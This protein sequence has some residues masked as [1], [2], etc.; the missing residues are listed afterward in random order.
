MPNRITHVVHCLCL[1]TIANE[2]AYCK[3]PTCRSALWRDANILGG[4][5]LIVAID[6]AI[7]VGAGHS[8]G[9]GGCSEAGDGKAHDG[10]KNLLQT[11][12]APAAVTCNL[13]LVIGFAEKDKLPAKRPQPEDLKLSGKL[14]GS[15]CW[16][17]S[18]NFFDLSFLFMA[19]IDKSFCKSSLRHV[20]CYLNPTL[21]NWILPLP[22]SLSLDK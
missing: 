10:N 6:A 4:R 19:F 5:A 20:F 16:M 12:P 15:T 13:F 22:K 11:G 9:D 8:N 3:I 17:G 2:K 14:V 21:L 18:H 1:I 7:L